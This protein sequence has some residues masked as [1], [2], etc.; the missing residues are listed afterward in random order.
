MLLIPTKILIED[1]QVDMTFDADKVTFYVRGPNGT[2]ALHFDSTAHLTIP[3]NYDG[4]MA[5]LAEQ[6]DGD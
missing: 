5:Y 6:D 2:T 3:Y 4:L 1:Q